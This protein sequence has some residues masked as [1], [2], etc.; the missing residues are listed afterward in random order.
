[1]TL[2]TAVVLLETCVIVHCA[3]VVLS[4]AMV[5]E[6]VLGVALIVTD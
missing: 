3:P 1:M 4:S 2:D 5:T 6:R